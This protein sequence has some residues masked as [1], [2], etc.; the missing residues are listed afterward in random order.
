MSKK[1][2]KKLETN[3]L[4][5]ADYTITLTHKAKEIIEKRY[6]SS[7]TA[8][9]IEVIPCCSDLRLFDYSNISEKETLERKKELGIAPESFVVSY[10]GSIGTW[11]M[12]DEMLKF[13]KVLQQEKPTSVFLFITRDH[14]QAIYSVSD[15]LQIDRSRIVI[16][17]T[18]RNETPLYISISNISIFFILPSFSKQ[19]SSPTK[20]GE[21]MG[22]GI[23]IIC[24]ANVGD[25]ETIVNDTGCGICI[26][27]LSETSFKEACNQIER[28][29]TIPKSKIRAGAFKYYSLYEGSN[30]YH[31]V[32]ER[33][34]EIK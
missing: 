31:N 14:P 32:Y 18:D 26:K 17:P 21:I 13:F 10:I 23:P 7:S 30:L 33:V 29:F 27:E 3:F 28:L 1:Y 5:N 8:P 11:Y 15:T 34:C 2:F 9:P 12:L 22:M 19:A 20:M 25:V 24:N 6:S 16:K 4:N